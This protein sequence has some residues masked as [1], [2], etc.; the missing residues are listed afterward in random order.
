MA[1]TREAVIAH[2]VTALGT[3]SIAGG[4][5]FDWGL[6]SR[7]LVDWDDIPDDRFPACCLA[8]DEETSEPHSFGTYRND[9]PITLCGYIDQPENAAR[10]ARSKAVEKGVQDLKK[11]AVADRTRGAIAITTT[12]GKT[13]IQ[14]GL[15]SPYN[16]FEVDVVIV[17]DNLIASP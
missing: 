2:L 11:A 15:V 16:Y 13:R 14:N 17:Y 10:D 7:E 12:W 4:Y 6:I 3:M 5:N 1:T 8:Y 9:L